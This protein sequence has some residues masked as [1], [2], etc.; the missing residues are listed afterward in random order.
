MIENRENGRNGIQMECAFKPIHCERRKRIVNKNKDQRRFLLGLMLCFSG[1]SAVCNVSAL[2]D[3]V[4]NARESAIRD[5]ALTHALPR[6][7]TAISPSVEMPPQAV[8]KID[9]ELP[10]RVSSR[11]PDTSTVV[12]TIAATADTPAPVFSK[13]QLRAVVTATASTAI[14][15]QTPPDP[16]LSDVPLPSVP[17]DSTSVDSPGDAASG[18]A[19]KP[20][21]FVLV[22]VGDTGLNAHNQKVRPAKAIR[23][24]RG[25]DWDWTTRKIAPLIDGHVNFANV[26]TVVTD[27]NKHYPSPKSFN[28]RMHTNGA[29][30]LVDVGFNVFSLAN[31]HSADYGR[32]GVRDTLKNAE[33]LRTAGLRAYAGLGLDRASAI[34]S[35][36]FSI[37]QARFGFAAMGIGAR[38][39]GPSRAGV[40]KPG[41]VNIYGKE[42]FNAV[43]D[44][45]VEVSADFRILSMHFGAE[46]NVR[47]LPGQVKKWRDDV[48]VGRGIDLIVGHHAHVVQGV[49]ITDGKLIFY[50]LGNFLHMGM[51]DMSKFNA[52]RDYGLL[53]RVFV[54][55]QPDGTMEAQAVQVVPL[56]DMHLQARAHPVKSAGRRIDIL[57]MLAEELD[58]DLAGSRGVRFAKQ[59]D[60]SGLYCR[61]S[62][63]QGPGRLGK[64][65]ADF[66]PA[67]SL[68][69]TQRR[70]LRGMC[71]YTPRVASR[72]KAGSRRASKSKKRRKKWTG[73]NVFNR[74]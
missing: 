72:K 24:G 67:P 69:I 30:H 25:Y 7:L 66:V 62:A 53:A 26:E 43:V 64:L 54:V 52:C 74:Q 41:Q 20:E 4:S 70:R 34:K 14:Q 71:S 73:R 57:N 21:L 18:D 51:Q 8:I 50:G 16:A 15:V 68:T 35:Q 56:T 17:P 12:P 47:P 37:G 60:G 32:D 36:T 58:D 3:E 2:A 29:R 13:R 28:F 61:P 23:H 45:L 6:A 33:I 1:V 39:P 19:P 9:P 59:V 38:Q 40:N 49:Q 27:H 10:Q 42:D 5:M 22:L 46:R 44:D 55:R 31:N 65:C 48:Q 63:A 11:H